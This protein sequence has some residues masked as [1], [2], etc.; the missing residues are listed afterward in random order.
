MK[1]KLN[2]I[3]IIL[4]LIFI[5]ISVYVGYINSFKGNNGL[6]LLIL[7][8]VL[9]IIGLAFSPKLWEY[10]ACIIDL[11]VMFFSKS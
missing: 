9:T 8:T 10:L 3:S 2:I 7:G 5:V 6:I 11:V 4:G 1:S